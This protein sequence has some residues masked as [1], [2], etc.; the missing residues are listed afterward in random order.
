MKNKNFSLQLEYELLEQFICNRPLG[1]RKTMAASLA[2]A[3]R[4]HQE[5]YGLSFLD[6]TNTNGW[7]PKWLKSYSCSVGSQAI[8]LGY[9]NQFW[10]W[11]F[12]QNI[13]SDNVLRFTIFSDLVQGVEPTL[14]LPPELHRYF[15]GYV[16]P[17]V[18]TRESVKQ[19][20]NSLYSYIRFV[21][22]QP[23]AGHF[24]IQE[25][26]DINR[27]QD[28]LLQNSKRSFNAVYNV[29]SH[30]KHFSEHLVA[31]KKLEFNPI[32]LLLS[33]H[34]S[35]QCKL[36]TALQA[37]DPKSALKRLSPKRWFRSHLASEM[38]E[39][40]EW[41]RLSGCKF[42]AG[43]T[44]LRAFDSFLLKQNIDPVTEF[45][46]NDFAETQK[47]VAPVTRNDRLRLARNFCKY[48][49]RNHPEK[50]D[51][52][53]M[54]LTPKARSQRRPYI[55]M[56]E[57]FKKLIDQVHIE[58]E[59]CRNPLTVEGI[60]IVLELMYATGLRIGEVFRLKIQD[61]NFDENTLFIRQTKFNKDRI[62]PFSDSVK[63][64][65]CQF[66]RIRQ[67]ASPSPYRNAELFFPT[68][69]HFPVNV[70]F[71]GSK[72]RAAAKAVCGLGPSGR[73][74]PR[75]HDL[76]HSNAV[77]ILQLWYQGGTDVQHRLPILSTYLGHVSFISTQKYITM[78]SELRNAAS[79]RLNNYSGNII[80]PNKGK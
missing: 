11:L 14:T 80:T 36:I 73:N 65:L 18:L 21:A 23:E 45:I 12:S 13:I 70:A 1:S 15:H 10:Q 27:I 4:K 38:N 5:I 68:S 51:I 76:R 48:L 37:D 24:S 3:S 46:L 25:V 71:V 32:D 53:V 43:K 54:G 59:V 42:K 22:Q 55:I 41:K 75:I 7:I 16:N 52:F 61:V 69:L 63:N 67:K 60:I 64:M 9:I 28:F 6:H 29:C 34:G 78:T 30:I 56:P 50:V 20:H 44:I 40:V 49:Q 17:C 66:V 8:Y 62:V 2:L 47:N 77:R 79:M 33:Q 58:C 72:F 74:Y 57:L 39:F 26:F 19:Y 35:N 31:L